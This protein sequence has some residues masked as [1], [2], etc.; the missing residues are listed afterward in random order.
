MDMKKRTIIISVVAAMAIL[1]LIPFLKK[2]EKVEYRLN[3]VVA[4]IG[5]VTNS[6]TATGTIE[7]IEQVEVGTQV[8]GVI[9][10]IHVDFNSVVKK[11]QLLAELDQS[12]LMARVLQSRASLA[13]AKN[14]YNYQSQ[15][16]NR[17]KTLF[18]SEMVSETDYESALYK[19]NN[20]K[21]SIDRLVSEVDQAE[22]NLAYATIY[23]PID[24]VVLDKTVEEGQTV[25]ASF[26]TPTLFTIARDL[27]RMQVEANVDEADIG[28]VALG[29]R[30]TFL[31]DAYPDDE[32]LG[33]ISQIRLKPTVSSN[34]VTYTVIIDAPNP[35]LKLKPGLT[36][37][38][39]I[40]TKESTDVITLPVS[41]LNFN[42]GPE[43]MKTYTMEKPGERSEKPPMTPGSDKRPIDS[44]KDKPKMV[45]VKN[46]KELGPRMVETGLTDRA[47]IAITKG[48]SIGDTIVTS[49]ETVSLTKKEQVPNS[50]FMPAR[51]GR[52]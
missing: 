31:V 27:T 29:Q 44:K 15:S 19:L 52:R 8:S 46:G 50:P 39:T 1:A 32:F 35:E 43:L 34:V 14:E 30:V 47:N 51:P 23:S 42:P 5:S 38:I 9:N 18:D 36:A 33:S 49:M 20:A 10:K 3:T 22:V 48:I 7:P 41:A 24:G 4:A 45:W 6:V 21:A 11:G 28:Q 17:I 13:S 26:N 40:I 16:Y 2:G 12:T 25:A 37:N